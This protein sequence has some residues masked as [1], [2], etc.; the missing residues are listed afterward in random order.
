MKKK[1]LQNFLKK[2]FKIKVTSVQSELLQ[3]LL[4]IL[5]YE[6][7]DSK[8]NIS[9]LDKSFLYVYDTKKIRNGINSEQFL[10]HDNR[11]LTFDEF[12]NEIE[13]ELNGKL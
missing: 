10:R 11:E 6:W 4:F 8:K 12:I 9:H 2:D 5:G 13:Q 3:K 1:V 7:P